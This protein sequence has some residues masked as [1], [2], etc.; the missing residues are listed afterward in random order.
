[1]SGGILGLQSSK[2]DRRLAAC[3]LSVGTCEIWFPEQGS[4]PGP[5][6][7]ECGLIHWT[8][9]KPR[10]SLIPSFSP[11]VSPFLQ[12]LPFC[13]SWNQQTKPCPH[14]LHAPGPI[15]ARGRWQRELH[16]QKGQLPSL[17]VRVLGQWGVC[18]WEGRTRDRQKGQSECQTCCRLFGSFQNTGPMQ[19]SHGVNPP[20]VFRWIS[21]D[22]RHIDNINHSL[23]EKQSGFLRSCICVIPEFKQ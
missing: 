10:S 20:F 23:L 2:W 12:L 6:H 17:Y 16:Q 1:M 7:W 8:T 15:T 18:A 13:A 21:H 5:L 11:S 22:R 9:M 19:S 3:E 4:H 14:S